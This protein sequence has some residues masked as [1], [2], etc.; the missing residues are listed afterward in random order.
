MTDTLGGVVSFAYDLAGQQTSVTNPRGKTT[1]YAY[2]SLGNQLSQ[3][4]PLNRT[5][6]NVYNLAGE[7]TQTTDARGV[8]VTYA[9]DQ[10]PD[11][12]S[13]GI[14]MPDGYPIGRLTRVV[15]WAG[16]HL[17]SYDARGRETD[18]RHVISGTTYDL[19]HSFDSFNRETC[20]V[21]PDGEK[22]G[23]VFD[24]QGVV[25]TLEQYPNVGCA[26]TPTATYLSS[27]TYNAASLPSTLAYGNGLNVTFGYR[28]SD[29]RLNSITTGALLNYSYGFDGKGNINSIADSIEGTTQSLVYDHR[30]RLDQV[31]GLPSTAVDYTDNEIGNLTMKQE[32]ASYYTSMTYPSG[33]SP[34]PHAVT[35]AN[36]PGGYHT[37][38]YDANGN[39]TGEYDNTGAVVHEYSYN[40]EGMTYARTSPGQNPSAVFY[41]YDADGKL[42]R[43]TPAGPGAGTVYIAEMY[44]KD[45]YTG[46]VVKYY[47][48]GGQR[49]AMRKGG[50]L[51]YLTQDHLGGTALVTD[52]SGAMTSRIRYFPYGGV[53]TIDGTNPPPTDK[54]FTG[55]QRETT[56]GIYHYKARLYNADIGRMPQAD[57]LVPNYVD[58]Q[59]YNRYSYAGNNPTNYIDPTGR[60][61]CRADGNFTEYFMP[62]GGS[63]ED[64]YQVRVTCQRLGPPVAIWAISLVARLPLPFYPPSGFFGWLKYFT[65]VRSIASCSQPTTN[66]C[67]IHGK[68]VV[69]SQ[70]IFAHL[71]CVSY[72]EISPTGGTRPRCN[73]TA[74]Y[75]D[76]EGHFQWFYPT[77]GL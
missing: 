39:M 25:E 47:F 34:R 55:Q 68:A 27:T 50:T 13:S 31:T 35:Q 10:T 52:T 9:Y 58:P 18:E 5:Q 76:F 37:F 75:V 1:T 64:P 60:N 26:G 54:L 48:A 59:A 51:Y 22:V 2:D 72:V 61:L 29:W 16:E 4:D 11:T 40:A 53:R 21:Y 46:E 65:D 24:N 6:A 3:T 62:Y 30:D 20:T 66:T 73:W 74:F 33:G 12:Y 77:G 67:T 19:G 23:S 43:K 69:D 17:H 28:S 7:L 57:S 8:I 71:V 70:T 32:G 42:S 56:N 36:Y 49:I 14:G 38:Q 41:T 45:T 15:D 44:E 63:A